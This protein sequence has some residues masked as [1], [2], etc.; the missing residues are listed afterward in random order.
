MSARPL[1][2]QISMIPKGLR[3]RFAPSPTGYLHLG[4]VAS[5]I[6]VWGLGR[7]VGADILLRIEDHDQGRVR[8]HFESSILYDLAWL[9]FDPDLGVRDAA[10]PSAFRQ[11]DHIERYGEALQSLSTKL[12]QCQ[13]SRKEIVTRTG[14]TGEELWYDG[15][16]RK[17]NFGPNLRL[18]L[19][20]DVQTFVD[21][22]LGEQQQIPAQQCGDLLLRDRDGCFTYNFAVTVDDIDES[23]GLIIRGQDILSATG[24]QLAL[25]QA[26]GVSTKPIYFH[27]PLIWADPTKKLS[28]RDRSTSIGQWRDQGLS[29]ADI[30]GKAAFQIGLTRVEEP[31][32]AKDVEALFDE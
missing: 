7:K 18:T 8:K 20:E 27:H 26:L 22:F 29:A 28:K 2:E 32:A 6:Y 5:A 16:C 4:H 15:Y 14:K 3:T 17:L 23:I 24:R 9:G 12:Y 21:G 11:S 13:C 25:R 31:L 19:T 1:I 30:I 10:Q